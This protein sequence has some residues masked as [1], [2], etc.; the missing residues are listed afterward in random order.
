MKITSLQNEKIKQTVRLRNRKERDESGLFLIEGYRELKRAIDA[1]IEIETLYFY[2]ALFVE[3]GQHRLVAGLEEIAIECIES[4][5]TKISYRDS[6]DGLLAVAKQM[7]RK[8]SDLDE[9]LA[10]KKNPFL[11]IAESIEKPGNLGTILRS[12]DAAGVDAVLVCD[13]TTD[14]YNPNVVRSSIGTLFTIPV[15]QTNSLKTLNFLKE[16]MVFT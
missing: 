7:R 6:P 5:F 13:P 14:I 15:I 12:C 11:V 16:K 2:P 3:S 10:T 9:I 8:L 4:V 1:G